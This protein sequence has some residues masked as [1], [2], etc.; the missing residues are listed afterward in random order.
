[1][2]QAMVYSM[3]H[4]SGLVHK[5]PNVE[6]DLFV[7]LEPSFLFVH[8]RYLIQAYKNYQARISHLFT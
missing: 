8:A 2:A 5:A 6:T 1:M 3:L 4:V 7:L